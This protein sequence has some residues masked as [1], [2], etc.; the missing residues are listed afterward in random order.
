MSTLGNIKTEIK[1]IL[2]TLVPASLAAV[3]ILDVKKDPLDGDI[4]GFPHAFIYPPS[5][6]SAGWIDNK[7][8]QREYVFA[9]MILMKGENVTSSSQVEDLMEV[10][11]NTLENEITLNG[12]AQAGILPSTS[13]PEAY[14]HGDKT[15]IVFDIIIRARALNTIS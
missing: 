1:T 12:T 8:A 3:E 4:I 7:T 11:M 5:L 15:Y 9:I 2:D 13:R 10:I 14:K 6:E